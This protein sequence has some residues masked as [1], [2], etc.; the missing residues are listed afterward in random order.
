M[1]LHFRYLPFVIYNFAARQNT[2]SKMQSDFSQNTQAFSL[3]QRI[4]PQQFTLFF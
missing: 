2:K 3:Q 1:C 4:Y